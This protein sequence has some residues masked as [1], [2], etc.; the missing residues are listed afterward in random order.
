MRKMRSD[1]FHR[2]KACD[3]T[4]LADYSRYSID[5][6]EKNQGNSFDGVRECFFK[7]E[8]K[9][10]IKVCSKIKEKGYK[11]FVQP[12]DIL[13][14]SDLELLELVDEV[15]IIEPYCLSIVDTF[16][17]MYIEDLKRLFTIIDH[18]LTQNCK[19]GF[20]SHNNMQLSNALSQEFLTISNGKRDVVVD[21][22]LCGMGRGAGNTP[23]E[24]IVQYM[25]SNLGYPYNMDAILDTI[26]GYMDN[27]QTKCNWGYNTSYFIAG[28]YGA[29][30]N[31]ISYLMNKNGIRSKDIRFILNKIGAIPRKR[32]D[33]DLL[34][35]TYHEY[36]NA[37]IDD[38]KEI[39]YL[40][41]VMRGHS[42]LLIA[43]GKQAMLMKEKIKF[44]QRTEEPIVIGVNYIPEDVEIDYLFISNVKR[45]DYWSN[46]DGFNHTKKILTSN[47]IKKQ[48][49]TGEIIVS[50]VGLVKPEGDYTDNAMIMLLRLL[51]KLEVQQI[52]IAGFDGY[53]LKIEEHLNYANNDM[54]SKQ[55]HRDLEKL[56]LEIELM[57]KDYLATREHATKIN[58]ITTSRFEKLLRQYK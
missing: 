46:T 38:R 11:V 41:S 21:A 42:V 37:E 18:N 15:N 58:F 2:K 56:N 32:Y 23:T 13:G 40:K 43:P 49:N 57:L 6:L 50:Y 19:I 16:G 17:S 30:V 39:Q 5:N 47:I 29:H 25:I 52:S 45:Y 22:T 28:A 36:M 7:K 51:D 9:D 53:Q 24:L 55:R 4:V 48:H 34:E 1:S 44:Q 20:H 8:W 12:V 14:Y 27:I 31:N 35:S 26:D 54:C 33:Y 3:F 10:A